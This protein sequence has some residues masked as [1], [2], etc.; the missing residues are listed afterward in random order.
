MAASEQARRLEVFSAIQ[1]RAV[2]KRLGVVRLAPWPTIAGCLTVL[3]TSRAGS[4]YLAR[5]L[6]CA[7]EIGRMRESFNP[8]AVK[9]RPGAEIVAGREDPWFSFKAGCA[10][11]IAAEFCG[12]FDAYLSQTSFILLLRRDIVAQAVSCVKALQTGQFH[13]TQKAKR[14]T[15]YDAAQISHSISIIVGGAEKLRR[16]AERSG[17]PWRTLLYED[18]A[19]GDFEGA[20]AACDSLGVPRR[21][22]DAQIAPMP[23]ERLSDATNAEWAARFRE[24]A[25]PPI[26]D[27]IER[28]VAR[29]NEPAP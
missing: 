4:T 21:P 29:V 25:T 1:T 6:E 13:S 28:Y 26:R 10:G 3:F 23:V 8:P 17:R 27:R 11:M 12:F 20:R 16:Y 24:Q 19:Q 15:T 22:P 2:D 5:E 9:G 7:F 18:F 14:A